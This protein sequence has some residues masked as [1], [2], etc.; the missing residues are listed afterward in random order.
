M[1]NVKKIDF[2]YK[3]LDDS[4]ELLE[5]TIHVEQWNKNPYAMNNF[6]LKVNNHLLQN[7]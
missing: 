7:I 2:D 5:K 6:L 1:K 4:Q 3:L